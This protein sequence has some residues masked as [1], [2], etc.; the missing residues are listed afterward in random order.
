MESIQQQ[1]L[2]LQKIKPYNKRGMITLTSHSK[3]ETAQKKI[4][5]LQEKLSRI[6]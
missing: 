2:E 1:I 3:W 6:N 4:K 5:K